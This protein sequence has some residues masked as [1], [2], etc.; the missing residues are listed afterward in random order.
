MRKRLARDRAEARCEKWSLQYG[1]GGAFR[2]L[3]SKGFTLIELLVVIAIIAILAAM[4][5]PALSRAK[6][7]ARSIQCLSNQ[8]QIDLS[9]AMVRDLGQGRLD[10]KEVGD[11]QEQEIGLP[12]RAIWICPNAPMIQDRTAL[13]GNNGR[14]T[15]GTVRSAWV[16]NNWYG[17]FGALDDWGPAELRT[18]SYTL[19][20][21][22]CGSARGWDSMGGGRPW[23]AF[24]GDFVNES[25]VQ[26]PSRTPVVVEGSWIWTS[27]G[28]TIGHQQT[29]KVL[30]WA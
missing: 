3:K 23:P 27:Q 24:P 19:N 17:W 1:G 29:W 15:Q 2:A 16:Q 12:H 22:L 28:R 26:Q 6:D 20:G 18:S 21:W 13:V 11:W 14:S 7:K 5:L 30:F 8:R 10:G 9:Y 4:L 25:Q